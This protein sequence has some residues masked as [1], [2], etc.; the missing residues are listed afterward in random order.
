VLA[1]EWGE[2]VAERLAERHIAVRLD[3]RPDDVR[4]AVITRA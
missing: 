3:R 1:V 4:T 2:G